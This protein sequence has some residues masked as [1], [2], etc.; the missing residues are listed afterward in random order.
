MSEGTAAENQAS[1]ATTNGKPTPDSQGQQEQSTLIDEISKATLPQEG[2]QSQS[3][4]KTEETKG[5]KK[6]AKAQETSGAPEKYEDFKAP[7][8]T[9]LDAEVVKTFSEVA[10]SL[11]L[12]QAKAQEVIDKLAPKLAERQ[13]EV[14]KQTNAIWRDKSLHDQVIGGDNWKNTIFSA[15]RALK[16]FQ[17]PEGE[18][19]DPDVYELATFA[20]NHPGLIKVLKHFGDNMREDKTIRGSSNRTLTPDDIYGK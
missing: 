16:E 2:Q 11:N 12:P 20:G 10:K 17:N 14:L 19:T 5:E 18:F 13:I 9:T 4:E 7:E 3:E 8:G 15:Q 1:E 6:E